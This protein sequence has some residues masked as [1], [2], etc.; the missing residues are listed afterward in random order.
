MAEGGVILHEDSGEFSLDGEH[1]G[2]IEGAGVNNCGKC[3]KDAENG[4]R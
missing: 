1:I 2:G 4:A 3:G